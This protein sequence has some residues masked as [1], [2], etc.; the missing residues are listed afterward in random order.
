MKTH[1]LPW[2][3][4]GLALGAVLFTAT[5]VQGAVVTRRLG[6]G[7]PPAVAGDDLP[8]AW[9]APAEKPPAIDGRLDERAWSKTRPIVLGQ[10]QRA[11]ETSPR[12][13]VR[14]SCHGGILYVG[15]KLA[16]P[17]V[18]KLKRTVTRHDGPAWEDDSVE[19]FLAP[20]ADRDYYQIVVSASGAIYDRRG[21]GDPADWDSKA[22]AAVH[23]G[24]D[25][26]SLEVAVPMA[27]LGVGRQVPQRWRVNVYRNRQAGGKGENQAWSPTFSGDYN[28]P[29]R[30]GYLLFTPEAPWANREQTAVRER[31]ITLERLG[32]EEAVLHFDLSGLPKAARIYRASLQCERQP[33]DGG[34]PRAL[35]NVEIYP[36]A[37]PYRKGSPPQTEDKP[38]SP[39]PPWYQSFD[40]TGLVRGWLAGRPGSGVYVKKFPGWLVGKTCLDLMYEG[41][42]AGVPPQASDVKAFHRAG[43]TFITWKEIDDLLGKDEATWSEVKA[44]LDG[45]DAKAQVRYCVYRS[46]KPITAASL[47]QAELL[48]TVKPLS[49][50]NLNGRNI[51]RPIDIVIAGK[52]YFPCG[53][54]NPF[55]AASL[56]GE[57]GRDCPIDRLVIRDGGQPL[58]RCTGLY[59]HTPTA[60]GT[61]YYAV[62]TVVDG[63]ANARDL[64]ARNVSEAVE[65]TPAEPVPVLQKEMPRMPFFNFAGKRLHYV[66]WVAGPKL[67]NVPSQYYNWSVAIPEPVP[68]AG[69][70]AAPAPLELTLH[71]DGNSYWRTQF[72]IERNSIVLAPYDF[73]IRSWW[74]GYHE[75]SGTL[76][77]CSQ[78]VIRPYTERRLLAFVDWAAR[79][80]PVDRDKIIVS[81]CRGG[82]S[83]AGALHL[84][85]RHPDVF[86]LVISGHGS[87]TYADLAAGLHHNAL[88]PDAKGLQAVFGAPEWALKTET[89]RVFYEEQDMV[90]L[91][92][93][94]PAKVELPLVAVTSSNKGSIRDFHRV[95]LAGGRPLVAEFW[96]GGG[97][98]IPVTAGETFP[99]AV[100]LDVRKDVSMLAFD[101]DAARKTLAGGMGEFNR[102]FTWREPSDQP[103]K[104]EV[105]I[106]N[107]SAEDPG[108]AKASL[109]DITLRRLRKFKVEPGKTYHWAVAP[110]GGKAP[111]F[112]PAKKT[113]PAKDDALRA[114]E[115]NATAGEDGLLTLKGVPLGGEIRLTVVPGVTP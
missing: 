26:W 90:K 45:L 72:R 5:A 106:G 76:R 25:G 39:L 46:A 85:L 101:S 70:K 6:T 71:R 97:R 42:P 82:A 84:G 102:G 16:E 7:L 59:V 110:L 32:D 27:S 80:W 31:G 41:E 9:A 77:S 75:C 109:F 95:M 92:A 48:A 105:T 53:H 1:E 103:A 64:S 23:V 91:A 22:K 57:F 12:S 50:W 28:V 11:G 114:P 47:P 81:G 88:S 58:D 4:C 73:P 8:Q 61:A 86:A 89:G 100:R 69:G 112:K 15:A 13:E 83:A 74:Y 17:N 34:D 93:G 44:I 2:R 24:Q 21:L 56:D 35:E 49:G 29:E 20:D 65:E 30:F 67:A 52:D 51:E 40:V 78:G 63:V 94:T 38:L 108:A 60:Q 79:K 99:N 98:Y 107:S 113:R 3:R 55:N 18:E 87:P 96:W 115:G 54:W 104:Y 10:L 68:A 14:F 62:V 37:A 111:D 19:L 66:Q 43:Q 33:I 36:L